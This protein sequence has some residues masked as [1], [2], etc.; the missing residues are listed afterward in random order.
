MLEQAGVPRARRALRR[1]A[2]VRYARQ[3]Y[4]LTIPVNDGTPGP[5]HLRAMAE[6]FH[7]RHRETYGHDNP[8]EAIQIVN[9]RLSAIGRSL[10][11]PGPRR[12]S[13]LDRA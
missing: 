2:D 3:A 9:L 13:A 7:A 10:P 4:E 6:A 12:Q 11:E 8:D 1:F 5:D